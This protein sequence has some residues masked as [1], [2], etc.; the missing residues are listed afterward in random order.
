M[1]KR[2]SDFLVEFVGLALLLLGVFFLTMRLT[3][4]EEIYP[5]VFVMGLGLLMMG[6]EELQYKIIEN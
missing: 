2:L 6:R 1:E 5:T 4:G 3:L